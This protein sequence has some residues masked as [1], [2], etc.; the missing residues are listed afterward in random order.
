MRKQILLATL[1]VLWLAGT[2]GMAAEAGRPN[3]LLIMT[4][5]QSAEV[6]SCR[7]GDRYLK[8][9]ALDSLAASGMVFDRAYTAVPLCMPARTSI[10]T[11]RYPH[12]TGVLRNNIPKGGRLP[13]EF[14]CMGTYLRKAGYITAYSGKWHIGLNEKKSKFHG[15]T[16]L[17][18]RTKLKPPAD[19]NFDSRVAHAAVKFLEQKHDRPFLLVASFL[20][21]HNICEWARRQA[22]HRKKITMTCGDVGFAPESGD[23]LPP[24]PANMEIPK[25]EPDGLGV[26]RRAYQTPRGMFPVGQFTDDDWR[27]V[28]WAYYRMVEK[29]DREIGK[30]LDALRQSGLEEDTLVIFTSDHGDCVGAHRFNQKT[31]FF[32]ESTRVP[33]IV[34]WKGKTQAGISDAL[35]NTGIDILPTILE[36]AH[37]AQPKSLPGRSLM[38]LSLGRPVD[39]WRHFVV[40]ENDLYQAEGKVNGIRP[41]MKGRMVRSDRYKYCV[42]S[43]GNQREELYDLKKDPLETVN[44]ATV[45]EYRHVLLEHRTILENFAQAHHDQLVPKLLRNDVEPRP[46]SFKRPK[47][48]K[49]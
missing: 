32:E 8:T 40:S 16:I 33:L 22:G 23:T 44:L 10:F 29:V 1:A 15:F 12:E 42:Y 19:D 9:P 13:D 17:D 48:S 18:S 30:V 27:K 21:P 43:K 35:V 7:M 36:A 41:S 3:V 5:Q 46:F 45:P 47:G 14:V 20:N 6:M 11:G 2:A 38:D 31:V 24:A 34:S 28:R 4:D 49:R 25:N 39:S 37:V 26:L